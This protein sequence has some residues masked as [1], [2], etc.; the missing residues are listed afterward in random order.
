MSMTTVNVYG[1]N[2]ALGT[3]VKQVNHGQ[4]QKAATTIVMSCC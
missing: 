4:S 3:G 2:M 1:N